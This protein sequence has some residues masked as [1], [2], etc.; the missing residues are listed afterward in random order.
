MIHK[1]SNIKFRDRKSLDLQYIYVEAHNTA[2]AL[3][4]VT[5]IFESSPICN[6]EVCEE[7][8]PDYDQ[9]V[10]WWL[11]KH[12]IDAFYAGQLSFEEVLKCV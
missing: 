6:I 12:H 10:T 1:I 3:Q 11:F 5:D 9:G 8:L 4:Y 7:N 2:T